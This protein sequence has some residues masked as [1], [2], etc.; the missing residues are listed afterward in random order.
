MV[1]EAASVSEDS[2]SEDSVLEDLALED[3]VG[4][5]VEDLD[6]EEASLAQSCG[7]NCS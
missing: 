5:V 1:S 2:A 3:L 4:L 6:S 7:R